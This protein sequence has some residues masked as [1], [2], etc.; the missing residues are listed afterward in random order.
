MFKSYERAYNER[1]GMP[2]TLRPGRNLAT[3]VTRQARENP[4]CAIMAEKS[5]TCA[6]CLLTQEKLAQAAVNGPCTE[7]CAYGLCEMAVPVQPRLA[8][9]GL[10]QTGQVMRRRQ[11]KP[12]M[13]ALLRKRGNLVWTSTLPRRGKLTFAT[14]VAPQKRL[15]SACQPPLHFR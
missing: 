6:A 11:P 10:L 4:F 12:P 5:R 7:T 1:T 15:D 14:P 2:V 13:A 3:A 8:T 9:I